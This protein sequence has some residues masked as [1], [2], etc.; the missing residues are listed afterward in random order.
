MKSSSSLL[1]RHIF[2]LL[3]LTVCMVGCIST[4]GARLYSDALR[5]ANEVALILT[6][7]GVTRVC[8]LSAK[9]GQQAKTMFTRISLEVLPGIYP[10]SISFMEQGYGSTL[11]GRNVDLT[12]KVEPDHTYV[13]YAKVDRKN[14]SWRP[15][16]VDLKDYNQDDCGGGCFSPSELQGYVAEHFRGK[17]PAMTQRSWG[18]WE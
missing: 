1:V 16:F 5:P 8:G 12:V 6:A 14:E 9:D 4:G 7:D 17:R 11:V 2:Q 10:F 3:T 18:G 15:V 13:L